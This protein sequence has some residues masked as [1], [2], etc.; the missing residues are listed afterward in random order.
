[1]NN[2]E[3]KK[4]F[5]EYK[6]YFLE[7]NSKLNLISKKEEEFLFEKH[8][9]DSLAI[10]LFF[11]QYNYM[12][13]TLLDIGTGGGF[14]SV[15]IAIEY[16]QI[17]VTGLDSI[18]KKINAVN[19]ICNSLKLRNIE[20]IND[21][22]ENIKNKTFDVV[23]SRAVGKI[24]KLIKYAYP[25]L[26]KGGYIVLYKSKTSEEEMDEAI[27]TIRKYQLKIKPEIVY[28]LPLEEKYIRKLIILQ[29]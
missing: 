2:F 27:S 24:D 13:E 8:I 14:P 12:P 20:L 26:K 19:S 5:T 11:N 22:A 18:G 16:P 17:S 4:D 21:R 23:T 15:P 28:E 29:K 3:T 6:K 9:Y 1:M 10:K 7:Q 25:L